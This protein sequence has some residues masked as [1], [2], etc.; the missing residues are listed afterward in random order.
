[1]IIFK[2]LNSLLTNRG[3]IALNI[4]SASIAFGLSSI[5][6]FNDAG[7]Y[8]ELAENL[9]NGSFAHCN[10]QSCIPDPVRT[11]GYPLILSFFFLFSKNLFLMKLIQLLFYFLTLWLGYKIIFKIS[12]SNMIAC[13]IFLIFTALNIQIPY[14]SGTIGTETFTVFFVMLFFYKLYVAEKRGFFQDAL[15]FS[16]IFAALYN[17]RPGFLLFPF[18]IFVLSFFKNFKLDPRQVLMQILFFL[19]M[20]LPFAQWKVSLR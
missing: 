11:P 10:S 13:N 4:T 8:I 3:L 14:Y 17:L 12:Q 15:T 5:T 7:H 18:I 9:L 16:L 6:V 19:C 2:Y 1:M 20:L